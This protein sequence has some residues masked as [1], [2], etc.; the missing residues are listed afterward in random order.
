ML[1]EIANFYPVD[2]LNTIAKNSTSVKPIWQAI[3]AHHGFQ[4]TGAHFLDFAIF[5]DLFQRLMSFIEDNFRVT[6][7]SITHHGDA[8]TADEELSPTLEN[9]AVLT[10]LRPIHPELPGLVKQR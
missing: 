4:S 2:S 10:W 6:N 3:R 9:L 5:R 7:G 1:G 8:I